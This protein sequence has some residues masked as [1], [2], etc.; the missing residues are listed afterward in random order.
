MI[1]GG[2]ATIYVS[3]MDRAVE[4]YTR[5]LGLK[6]ENRY[7]NEWASIDAGGGLKLGLHPTPSQH[8]AAA[9]RAVAAV[10]IGFDVEQPLEQ[11][12]AELR[13]RGVEL[14]DVPEDPKAEVRL[15][16]FHDPDGNGL[17]LYSPSSS[18]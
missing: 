3:D 7:G 6:L 17:Y 5:T 18:W 14:H 1:H 13:R 2:N 11:V 12:V 4:F 15:V 9:K 16:R 10:E 8:D